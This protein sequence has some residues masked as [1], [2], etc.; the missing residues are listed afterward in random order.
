MKLGNKATL[1]V[2]KSELGTLVWTHDGELVDGKNPHYTFVNSNKTELEINATSLKQAG[3]YEVSLKEGGCEIRIK[4]EVQIKGLYFLAISAIKKN[5][6]YIFIREIKKPSHCKLG[7]IKRVL[8]SRW[9]LHS[10]RRETNVLRLPM[11]RKIEVTFFPLK[12]LQQK[13]LGRKFG[14]FIKEQCYIRAEVFRLFSEKSL[15]IC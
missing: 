12:S 1:K 9:K 8:L 2:E 3:I 13:T 10:Y 15:R 5:K 14:A 4:I 11:T 7:V 6:N